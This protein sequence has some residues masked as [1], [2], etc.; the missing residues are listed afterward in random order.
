L[1]IVNCFIWD[2]GCFYVVVLGVGSEEV[3]MLRALW[4]VARRR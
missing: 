2:L 3:G 1:S 4:A